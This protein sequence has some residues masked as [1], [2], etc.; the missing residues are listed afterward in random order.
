MDFYIGSMVEHVFVPNGV[1]T[2]CKRVK[3]FAKAATE[4]VLSKFLGAGER[5]CNTR[6]IN[7][8]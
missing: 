2:N 7:S 4:A 6:S 5:L 3:G 1:V 8:T